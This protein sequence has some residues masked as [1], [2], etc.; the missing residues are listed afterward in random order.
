MAAIIGQRWKVY[1]FDE[2]SSTI[3][4]SGEL[5]IVTNTPN[6]GS[7]FIILCGDA[8]NTVAT[9]YVNWHNKSSTQF[10]LNA[11]T[12]SSTETSTGAVGITPLANLLQLIWAKI[13]SLV[14]AI[15]NVNTLA[16]NAMPRAGGAFSGTISIPSKTGAATNTGTAPASEAQVYLKQNKIPYGSSGTSWLLTQPITDG[17]NPGNKSISDFLLANTRGATNGVAPLDS[18]T[19][20]PVSYLSPIPSHLLPDNFAGMEVTDYDPG[21]YSYLETNRLLLVYE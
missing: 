18:S 21:E 11:E 10:S 2:I 9:L 20:I 3:P 17:G 7:E 8:I 1:N 4:E 19:K 12:G 6:Y 13:R 16:G 14:N 15:T 5:I